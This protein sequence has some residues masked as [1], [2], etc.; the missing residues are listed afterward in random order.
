MSAVLGKFSVDEVSE[1]D[2]ELEGDSG[3][4]LDEAGSESEDSCLFPSF[5]SSFFFDFWAFNLALSS[6]LQ[7]DN[8][9]YFGQ[10]CKFS[11]TI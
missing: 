10:A 1:A 3:V 6:A 8:L 5:S 11:R 2:S 9:D 4:G 7:V